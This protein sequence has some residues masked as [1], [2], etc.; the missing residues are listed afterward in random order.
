ML[1]ISALQVSAGFLE[2]METMTLLQF[3]AVLSP[4]PQICTSYA[5]SLQNE[6]MSISSTV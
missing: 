3:Y 5:Q 2:N 6:L 1:G 4:D